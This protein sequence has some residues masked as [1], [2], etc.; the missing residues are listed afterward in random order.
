MKKNGLLICLLL[1]ATLLSVLFS[2]CRKNCRYQ[3]CDLK[4]Y[5]SYRDIPGVTE[6]EIAAI[7][8]LRE[9]GRS[10]IYGMPRSSEAF[11][12]RNG[13]MR[14][15][16]GLTCEWLTELFGLTFTPA[17]YEWN[18]LLKGLES[19]EIS[20]TGE[21]TPTE[22]RRKVYHMT[23]AIASRPVMVFR[24]EGARPLWEISESRR[25]RSGFIRGTA[26]IKA[27]TNEM[28]E[29]T[30]EIVEIDDMS[31]VYDALKNGE[32]DAFYY[33]EVARLHFIEHIDISIQR[34]Y[35]LIFMPVSLSTQ[36]S[37]LAPVISVVDKALK[38]NGLQYLTKLYNQS[39]WEY[40]KFKLHSRLTEEEHDYIVNNPIIP[41]GVDPG[42]Y[43][44]SFYDRREKAWRGISLDILDE[45]GALTGLTFKRVN[46]ENAAWPQIY[47]MLKDG[48]IA[49]VPELAQFDKREGRFIWPQ[50]V[51]MTDYYVLISNIEY[52]N[53][54]PN[55]VLYVKV[56]LVKNTDYFA[57][58]K[59]WFPNH[60]NTVE[61]ESM[62]DAFNALLRGDVDMIMANQKS[63]LYLTHYLE[64]PNYKANVVFDYAVDIKFGLNKDEEIL[65]SIIDK[66]LASIDLRSITDY[67]IR[68]TYDYRSK[69]AEAQ[70]P[71]IIGA[72]MLSLFALILIVVIS[73][74]K[75]M[76]HRIAAERDA[77]EIASKSKSAFLANMSH[78]I[79]TPMNAILG[80]TE[81]LIQNGGLSEEVEN[82]LDKI[83]SSSGMLLGII[84]DILDFS[85]IEAGKLNVT[86]AE[87]SVAS[88]I[89]DTAQLNIMRIES[90]PILFEIKIEDNIPAKLFGDEL[91]I[92][93]ILNNLLSN[94]FKYTNSGRVTLTV[95]A[96]SLEQPQNEVMLV[97]SVQDTGHGMTKEQLD[98]LFDEYTRFEEKK[99]SVEGTG[100]G[101]AIT[102]R[103][104][105]LMNGKIHVES[106]PGFGTLLVVSLPQSKLDDEILGVDVAENLRK[107]RAN[108]IVQN[109]INR[110]LA[111]EPMPYGSVL[112]VDDVETNLYV[113]AGLLKLYRLQIDTAMSGRE[114]IEKIKTGKV[115]DIIFMDHMMPGMDGIET[116][117]RMRGMGYADPIVALTANAVTG[118]AE[119][120]LQNGFAEF[121]SKPIDI[122]QLNSVLNKLIRDKQQPEVIEYARQQKI[123]ELSGGAKVRPQMDTLLL[124]SFV[125]D[126]RKVVIMLEEQNKE[127]GWIKR[128]DNLKTFTIMVHGI[129]S[130]LRS[131]E[132]VKLSEEACKLETAGRENNIDVITA[133]SP[134]FLN[135]LRGLIEQI[136]PKQSE[137]FASEIDFIDAP[138]F[139]Y[140]K[141]EKIRGACADYSRKSALDLSADVNNCSKKTRAVITEIKDYVIQSEYGKAEHAAA[142]YMDELSPA[143]R[144]G[145]I[146][147]AGKTKSRFHNRE[148]D[149]LDIAKGLELYEG[150]EEA[151]LRVLRAYMTDLRSM[152]YSIEGVSGNNLVDY[153]RT[154]HS[155]KGMSRSIFAQGLGEDAASLET[156]A[157]EGDLS[158]INSRN[159]GFLDDVKKLVFDLEN[160]I[161]AIDAENEK[162]K[163][164]KPDKKLL[165]GLCNACKEFSMD[166]VLAAIEEIEKYDY[167]ED[168]GLAVWLREN[169]DRINFRQIVERL[170]GSREEHT[171]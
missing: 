170:S 41:I 83:H 134:G 19:G 106:T 138:E 116:T 32:I 129:K 122:R 68:K 57:V 97:L 7:E 141:L 144:G 117:K 167:T 46:D 2:G 53:I 89:N 71:W 24:L 21:L 94:A 95:E 14:C 11:K 163:K 20:F 22:E 98:K 101:L 110:H 87:Y 103:L 159:K 123:N 168:E 31:L 111:R 69:V 47:Q 96:K 58:F 90:K 135:E 56:G 115:Y 18:N 66:A 13:E 70:V 15:F 139:L 108:N 151:Y 29:G 119:V 9:Q 30:F 86:P 67:W 3:Y 43:P 131:I 23:G 112:I 91:R 153:E 82:G 145:E 109:K 125:R 158:F 85:K 27:V 104:V 162:P 164:D 160:M 156:A 10:F 34:F 143:A 33:S 25:Q 154:V 157:K 128:G 48:E 102:Q 59:K 130:S 51:L 127:S 4:I 150:D 79:R 171:A 161:S 136:E 63:L 75:V 148:L 92:K 60:S 133:S 121:I 6:E 78:E 84:N 12:N 126:A 152:L 73:K 49:L 36:D 114:A 65:R 132:E 146:G 17:L 1:M 88:M 39:R 72:A 120:F 26:T 44:S 64:L 40:M 76:E 118:Q 61:Y 16:S 55:E 38:N 142:V 42:N 45:V 169:I 52:P 37:A 155:I 147:S 81:M 107:F 35:P 54:K 165:A 80:V 28:A 5:S 105:V 50:T 166:G 140:A 137:P 149:G 93:Q 77:A 100:L 74:R 124:E 113:A 62:E 8:A 99:N